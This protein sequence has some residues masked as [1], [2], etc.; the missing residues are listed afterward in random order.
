MSLTTTRLARTLDPSLV[1][2]FTLLKS[3]STTKCGG[4]PLRVA[5][6]WVR[7]M[8]L[9]KESNDIDIAIETPAGS[10]LITGAFFASQIE[11]FV[12]ESEGVNAGLTGTISVIKTNPEKSKHIETAQMKVLGVPLEFCHLRHDEYTSG[13]H[14]VPEVRPGSPL[15]DAMR[16]DFACNALFY[17]L[18]TELVEDFCGG[19]ADLRSGVLRCPLNPYETF[20]DD[21]LRM[22]RGVRFGGQLGFALHESITGALTTPQPP[23]DMPYPFSSDVGP[24]HPLVH[25]LLHK[26]SRERAAIELSKSLGGPRPRLCI[27]HLA[28][29]GLLQ[30]AVLVEAHFSE[31][32]KSRTA[33]PDIIV[34]MVPGATVELQSRMFAN[35]ELLHEVLEVTPE[36]ASTERIVASLSAV[37]EPVTQLAPAA[38]VAESTNSRIDGAVLRW[39][40]LPSRVSDGVKAVVSAAQVLRPLAQAL[41]SATMDSAD[42]DSAVIF[43]G[44]VRTAVF[45]ALKALCLEARSP[46]PRWAVTTAVALA[47]SQ[48]VEADG[49]RAVANAIAKDS[50]GSLLQSPVVPPLIRGDQ[51]SA[52][53]SISRNE[54]GKALDAQREFMLHNPGCSVQDVAAF[55]VQTFGTTPQQ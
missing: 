17:N 3:V 7:D 46:P 39:M 22:L 37:L 18:Q 23:L 15:E 4:A 52:H 42:S 11:A 43:A 5:G 2:I 6:G 26:V 54:T 32:P 55:L 36:K 34:P 24:L 50:G 44:E 21:P 48:S 1:R 38:V 19:L 16:R 10:P 47:L 51:L 9:G 20:M 35:L 45:T 31:K 8:L 28:R 33:R 29:L 49:I 41:V 30:T 12:R 13:D 25:A 53:I 40:K 14:R 27:E